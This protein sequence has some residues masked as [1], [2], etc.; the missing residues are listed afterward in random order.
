MTLRDII[1]THFSG[2]DEELA[3]RIRITEEELLLFFG[4]VHPLKKQI[5]ENLAVELDIPKAFMLRL[6][7]RNNPYCQTASRSDTSSLR[8]T[9]E[10][11][12]EAER[13]QLYAEENRR[14]ME[15]L[16]QQFLMIQQVN[17]MNQQLEQQM[18][19]QQLANQEFKFGD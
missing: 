12:E 9:E 3:R 5:A 19:F 7:D 11:R 13:Q 18:L 17:E 8:E 15:E 4:G 6:L 14:Q 10:E 2:T 16:H 1:E